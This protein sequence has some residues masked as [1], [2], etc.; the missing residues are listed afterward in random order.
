MTSDLTLSDTGLDFRSVVRAGG[1]E[2]AK[3]IQ[4]VSVPVCSESFL[5]LS[6]TADC[7]L[8]IHLKKKILCHHHSGVSSLWQFAEETISFSHPSFQLSL[9]TAP[10]IFFYL[11]FTK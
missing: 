4:I 2:G 6:L 1:G 10:F 5:V 3:V 7:C 11:L 8:F 9:K